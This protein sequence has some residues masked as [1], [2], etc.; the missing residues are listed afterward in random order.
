[1]PAIPPLQTPH[2]RRDQYFLDPR[3]IRPRHFLLQHPALLFAQ[4]RLYLPCPTPFLLH[5]HFPS[6]PSL[7]P[8]PPC[9]RFLPH[10]LPVLP[11]ALPLL[12][13][14]LFSQPL[15]PFPIQIT[16]TPQIQNFPCSLLLPQLLQILQQDAPRYPVHHQVMDDQQQPPLPLLQFEPSPLYQL[17]RLQVQARLQPRRLFFHPGSPPL[18]TFSSH[19]HSLYPPF[20]LLSSAAISLSPTPILPPFKPHP[21]RI[22]MLHQFSQRFLHPLHLRPRRRPQHH[23]LVKVPRLLQSLRKKPLLDR[24]QFHPPLGRPSFPPHLFHL[25][26]LLQLH[27]P[28]QP[29][30]CLILEDLLDAQPRYSRRP[31]FGHNLQTQD[32]ISP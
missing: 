21:Q 24:R 14:Q 1:M 30:H 10:S 4:L 26:H 31:R 2:H 19:I 28:R 18:P 27:L 20:P 23:C 6:F 11:L 12:P 9:P 5:F 8:Q 15:R 3:L 17:P 7:S 29:R 13:F 22:M 16:P 25:L 32:R